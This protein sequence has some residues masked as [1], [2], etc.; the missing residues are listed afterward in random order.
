M[1][2][3]RTDG[4]GAVGT[5]ARVA[6]AVGTKAWTPDG[7]LVVAHNNEAAKQAKG[8]MDQVRMMGMLDSNAAALGL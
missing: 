3:R 2:A 8:V 1:L 6:V 7:G 4:V 5:T